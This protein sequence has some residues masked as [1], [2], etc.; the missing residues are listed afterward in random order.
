MDRLEEKEIQA[1]VPVPE[2]TEENPEE[3]FRYPVP[4]EDA[5][6]VTSAT[7][8]FP[9]GELPSDP[10]LVTRPVSRGGIGKY[11]AL[12]VCAVFGA[13]AILVTAAGIKDAAGRTGVTFP[14]LLYGAVVNSGLSQVPKDGGGV[15]L[16]GRVRTPF[17][18]SALPDG[19][20]GVP[21]ALE[22]EGEEEK[23]GTVPED[24]AVFPIRSVSIPAS[25]PLTLINETDLDPDA[26]AVADAKREIPSAAQL[27]AEYGEGAPLVL[28]IHTHG[29]ESYSP[30]GADTYLSSDSFRSLDPEEGVVAV[31]ETVR[32][33]LETRGVATIHCDAMFD[34]QDFSSAYASSAETVLR[35]IGE[36]PSIRYVLD[37]HRD[38]LITEEGENLRPVTETAD[39]PAAQIMTVVGT[40]AAGADH[41]GWEENLNVALNLQKGVLSACPTLMRA[42]DLKP[43]SFNQQFAPGSLLI[44]AGAAA[45][46][47]AEAKR[48][49]AIF[50]AVF[51]DYVLGK[52]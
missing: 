11:I 42:V 3:E 8:P 25:D 38:A 29:T 50:A 2:K 19:T 27:Y 18:P 4:R 47:L 14:A 43:G 28:I 49:A 37:V 7:E 33:V 24:G 21:G 51:A 10:A 31:G 13:V 1:T 6:K 12:L 5:E 9:P 34:A 20:G 17:A 44:E 26:A 39:G 15:I 30:D 48:G 41:P 16:S 36:Y 46:S 22:P 40:N 23:N 45:N 52:R 35:I 32:E